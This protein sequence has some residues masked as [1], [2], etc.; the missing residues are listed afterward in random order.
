MHSNSYRMPTERM[1]SAAD[2]YTNERLVLVHEEG[3]VESNVPFCVHAAVQT[4]AG[5]STDV[6]DPSLVMIEAWQPTPR[7]L[8][9]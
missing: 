5:E 4:L 7:A 8:S 1:M 6:S 3:W 2:A 9:A